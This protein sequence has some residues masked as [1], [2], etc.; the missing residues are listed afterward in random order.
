M[1]FMSDHSCAVMGDRVDAQ[2]QLCIDVPK[3]YIHHTTGLYNRTK[4]VLTT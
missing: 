1:V 4:Q 2:K 3:T